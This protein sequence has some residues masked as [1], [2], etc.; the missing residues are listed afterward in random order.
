MQKNNT[1]IFYLMLF[2]VVRIKPSALANEPDS[3]YLFSYAT[4]KDK[5]RSGFHFAWSVDG[6]KWSMVGN[7]YGYV[8]S[9]KNFAFSNASATFLSP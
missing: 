1:R 7:E 8:R 2:L 9:G 6:K 4:L 5:G 3:V